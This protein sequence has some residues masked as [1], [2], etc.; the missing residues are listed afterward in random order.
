MPFESWEQ[1]NKKSPAMI[2][3][4]AL[5]AI[6]AIAGSAVA[7]YKIIS[8]ASDPVVVTPPSTLSKP[9]F[10]A[11][12]AVVGE[13]LQ[14]TTTLSDKTPAV[15][16]FFYQNNVPIGSSYTNNEGVAIFNRL[17][18]TTGSFIYT[19]ECVHP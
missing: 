6:L 3:V 7:V 11:T 18:T 10:N 14:I 16:V 12:S 19:A 8:P 13:T 2:A 5:I 4:L 15:E 9:T 1:D 17:L